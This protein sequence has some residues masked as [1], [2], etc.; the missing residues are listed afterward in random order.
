ME[1]QPAQAGLVCVVA[2]L[3]AQLKVLQNLQDLTN[4]FNA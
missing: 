1:F 4:S 3:T 2:V